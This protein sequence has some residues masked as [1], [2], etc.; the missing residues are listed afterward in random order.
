MGNSLERII[1]LVRK[2]HELAHLVYGHATHLLLFFF[3]SF[4]PPLSLWLSSLT[5]FRGA[6]IA[7]LSASLFRANLQRDVTGV[8]EKT[9][10]RRNRDPTK[11]GY[12]RKAREM[13]A[14]RADRQ[15]WTRGRP[16]SSNRDSYFCIAT[17]SPLSTRFVT[18]L[19][20][21][22]S[23]NR[24]YIYKHVR[25]ALV[26]KVVCQVFRLFFAVCFIFTLLAESMAT[27]LSI[28]P[29]I[30]HVPLPKQV[31]HTRGSCYP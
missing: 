6:A 12:T 14:Q 10:E 19:A 13:S 24:D 8:Y 26:S 4:S 28:S 16:P 23:M 21:K 29:E 9:R 27:E 2:I 1:G 11:S 3:F 5:L 25:E 17:S 7:L 22:R 15:W 30:G 31:A 18:E 20:K